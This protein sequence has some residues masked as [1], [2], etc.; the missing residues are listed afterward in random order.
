MVAAMAIQVDS[1]AAI[2]QEVVMVVVM[3]VMVAVMDT[4][5]IITVITIITI[6]FQMAKLFKSKLNPSEKLY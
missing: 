1:A 2:I 5:T 3:V 6:D 4:I